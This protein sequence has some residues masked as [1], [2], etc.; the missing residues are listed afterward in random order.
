MRYLPIEDYGIIGDLNTIALVGINGSIDFMCFPHF[1]SPS[2]FASLLDKEKGGY[3]SISPHFDES[4]NKQLY[5]PDTNVLLTRFLSSEG[6]GEM[7]DFMPVED[8]YEGKALIRRI[9]NIRGQA[10]YYMDC[11]PRFDYARCGHNAEV[12]DSRTVLFHCKSNNELTLRLQSTVDLEIHGNDVRAVFQL[13]PGETA[14][15]ILEIQTNKHPEKD[16]NQL[17]SRELTETVN[18]WKDWTGISKYNGRWREVVNRSALVLK[19]LTSYKYGSIAAAPT[20]SLPEHL[21]GNRNWD[22]RYCWIRDSS[23][24]LY[25]LINLGYTKEAANFI[26]WIEN[27][28]QDID[29][30]GGLKLMYTIEGKKEMDEKIL[31]H[32]EGYRG[33]SPVRIG[34]NAHTQLQLDIYGELMDSIYL[35]NK[36]G[37]PISYDFWKKIEGQI[38][39]VSN[40]WEQ[41]DEGIWEVRGG[42]K[43]FLHSRLMCWVAIDRAIKV[44]E[45]R[46]FPLNP[47]WRRQRDKI[48]NSIYDEFW[49]EDRQSFVQY[50]GA[51]T[52]DAALL[53]M[54]LVRF[55]SPTDPRWLSTLKAI[56]DDL[57]S[58][59]LV[60]RY[61]HEKAAKDGMKHGEGSFSMCSFWYVE[62]LARA[63]MLQKARLLFEKMIGYGNHLELYAEQLGFQGEHLGN[64]PQAFTH[65]GLISAAINLDEQLNNLRNRKRD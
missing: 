58:D 34:N 37:E 65:L 43:E 39:W 40:N 1:D 33:T 35:F 27:L 36:Y 30:P 4:R 7:T 62:C 25:S 55:I 54:P 20:F 47:E 9:T 42:R 6:V 22:Y 52:V 57:V 61:Q 18:Y 53:L 10:T 44:C 11:K 21:G 19:L 49:N 26:N 63:G 46:S 8:L 12:V 13:D 64:F 31:H 24:T 50:K 17:V 15:F 3:F 51:S 38:N 41:P 45:G 28:C 14:D 59:A 32:M 48:F 29:T 23:F 16:L 2:V 60:Y 5:L 56:E